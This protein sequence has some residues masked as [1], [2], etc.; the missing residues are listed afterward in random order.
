MKQRVQV[1]MDRADFNE[2]LGLLQDPGK[3]AERL[4]ALVQ[5]ED[6]TGPFMK[7]WSALEEALHNNENYELGE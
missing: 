4:R 7:L 3:C 1:W 2:L 6:D 5:L